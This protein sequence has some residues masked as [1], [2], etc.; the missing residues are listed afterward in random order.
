MDLVRTRGK[1]IGADSISHA[2]I[3]LAIRQA[4]EVDEE[5]PNTHFRFEM[6]L[7]CS[8]RCCL[9]SESPR[10]RAS[11][12]TGRCRQ[13]AL[14]G[15]VHFAPAPLPQ[16]HRHGRGHDGRDRLGSQKR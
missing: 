13:L 1:V 15:S 14:G 16:V 9:T 3:G 5:E 10:R 6:L 12:P 7:P 8:R 2:L 11:T 4:K